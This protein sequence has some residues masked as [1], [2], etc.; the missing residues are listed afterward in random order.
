MSESFRWPNG[1]KCAV[2]L[3]FDCDAEYVFM[4]NKPEIAEMPR[5]KSLGEYEWNAPVYHAF[6]IYSIST[7]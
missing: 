4:G 3:T 7:G 1:N 6:S 2:C 5:M